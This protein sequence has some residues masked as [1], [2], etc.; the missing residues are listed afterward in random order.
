LT[1]AD[2]PALLLELERRYP[3]DG[4]HHAITMDRVR[5]DGSFGPA[6]PDEMV[7]RMRLSLA[8]ADRPSVYLDAADFEKTWQELADD[9]TGLMVAAHG[10]FPVKL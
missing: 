8:I 7:P 2:V 6:K 9:V 1:F 3:P 5:M 10:Y 4:G